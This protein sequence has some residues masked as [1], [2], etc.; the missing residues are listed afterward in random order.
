[1]GEAV[2]VCTYSTTR[3]HTHTHTH[4]HTRTYTHS[5]SF[6]VSS[7][8]Y[9]LTRLLSFLPLSVFLGTTR[10]ITLC[11]S[12]PLA[13]MCVQRSPKSMQKVE[14]CDWTLLQNLCKKSNKIF[15]FLHRFWSVRVYYL[16]NF[17]LSFTFTFSSS[18]SSS[19]SSSLVLLLFDQI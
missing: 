15:Y 8:L 13:P 14:Y 16:R 17:L 12:P 1:M 4:T 18:S 6:F 3:T 5:I 11:A 7:L 19:S 2:E 10:P 9:P